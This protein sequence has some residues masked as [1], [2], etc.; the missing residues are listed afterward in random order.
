MARHSA[1]I[2]WVLLLAAFF[3]VYGVFVATPAL[4]ELDK[5]EPCGA[6]NPTAGIALHD[7][8]FILQLEPG[9]DREVHTEWLLDKIGV[10]PAS[11]DEKVVYHYCWALNGTWLRLTPG[12][13]ERA[14]RVIGT[15]P[16]G[17][18]S[19]EIATEV[20]A[21]YLP[22]SVVTA[23]YSLHSP[24]IIPSFLERIEWQPPS[25]PSVYA[26]VT[27]AILDTGVDTF[28]DDLN[29]VPGYDCTMEYPER[30]QIDPHGH[31]TLMA[32]VAGAIY[33]NDLGNAGAAAGI[34][35]IPIPVLGSLGYGTTA[36]VTC[37]L[38]QSMALGAD[39]VSMSL[40]GRHLQSEC[41]GWSA[42]HNAVCALYLNG[43]PVV[44]SAGNDGADVAGK[45]PAQYPEAITVSAIA[46]YANGAPVPG[47]SFGTPNN[48]QATFSNYGSLVNVASPAGVCARGAIPG[49][50]DAWVSGTSPAAP[51]V[52]GTIAAFI[53]TR[54]EDCHDTPGEA[55]RRVEDWSQ[56]WMSGD[57]IYEADGTGDG[58][59]ALASG[60]HYPPMIRWGAP[61]EA[62]R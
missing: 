26:G 62:T 10:V 21:P 20:S 58:D 23:D 11:R 2:K 48:T 54:H 56:E 40:G 52:A 24:E 37:G 18:L 59:Y 29:T 8:D 4:A 50:R 17:V 27:I 53:A 61:C 32:S 15:D 44:A 6:V 14:R 47:C 28:H 60:A 22:A 41:G 13:A 19:G 46:S 16:P 1:A 9:E 39:V 3:T 51:L 45:A 55:W 38:D 49:N 35:I 7:V 57:T 30:W 12:E 25:N 34:P 5:D 42:E 43:V 36:S 33:G 31:G